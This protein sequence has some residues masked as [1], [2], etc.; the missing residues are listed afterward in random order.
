MLQDRIYNTTLS[1]WWLRDVNDDAV[2]VARHCDA[3]FDT[4]LSRLGK[5]EDDTTLEGKT[6]KEHLTE[7]LHLTLRLKNMARRETY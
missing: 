7:M 4:L 1:V 3:I 6:K 2:R 5:L